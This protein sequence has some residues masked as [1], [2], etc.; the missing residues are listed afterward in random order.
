MITTFSRSHTFASRP[1]FSW[2]TPMVPGPQT[3]WVMRTSTFTQTLSPGETEDRPAARASTFSVRVIGIE[4]FLYSKEP[5]L[6]VRESRRLRQSAKPILENGGK[7]VK[8]AEFVAARV[9]EIDVGN[10]LEL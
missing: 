2:N 4:V 10:P 8:A 3:S 9:S 1:K 5:P 7:K 6:A